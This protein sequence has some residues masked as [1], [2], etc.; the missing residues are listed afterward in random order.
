MVARLPR[1]PAH[2]RDDAAESPS[3]AAAD[4]LPAPLMRPQPAPVPRPAILPAVAIASP[5]LA[6]FAEFVP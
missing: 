3:H 1:R 2:D 5:E 4:T 6:A